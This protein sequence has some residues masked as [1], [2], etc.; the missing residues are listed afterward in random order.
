MRLN[1]I[2]VIALLC[3]TSAAMA[4]DYRSKIN[5]GYDYYKNGEFDKAHEQFKDAGILKPDKALPAYDK[6][7]ALYRSK[8]FEGAAG[9]FENSVTK[10]DPRLKADAIYNAGNAYFKSEKYD[11]AVKSYIDAL[12]LKPKEKDYKHNLELALRQLKEQQQQKQN[13]NKNDKQDNKQQKQDQ[14]Q[15]KQ[16]EKKQ[17]RQQAQNQN[18]QKKEEQKQG[19]Q[20]NQ[21]L[22]EEQARDLLARFAEDEKETQKRL[23]QVNIRGRSINDW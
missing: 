16:D 22:T 13:Q 8:D 3:S 20:K 7:T 19:S 14:Q 23:K 10:N 21:Q 1:N 15:N 11:Q 5:E 9:E 12:K 17:D 4:D 2:M 6:G 18:E